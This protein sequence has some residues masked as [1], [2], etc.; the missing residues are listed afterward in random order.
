MF[1]DE[2]R[3]LRSWPVPVQDFARNVLIADEPESDKKRQ[4]LAEWKTTNASLEFSITPVATM[5]YDQVLSR[6]G[7]LVGGDTCDIV[8]EPVQFQLYPPLGPPD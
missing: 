3:P 7:D 5:A 1:T 2:P 4:L 6:F 8:A